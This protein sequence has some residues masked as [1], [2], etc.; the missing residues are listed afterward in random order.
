MCGA[1]SAW[2]H[3]GAIRDAHPPTCCQVPLAIATRNTPRGVN[4][5]L[6]AAGLPPDTFD[7]VLT[8]ESPFPEKPD[9]AIVLAACAAWGVPPDT[10]LMVGDTMDDMR[11]GSGAG[12]GTCLIRPPSDDVL[13]EDGSLVD[14]VIHS[15]CELEAMINDA[16]EAS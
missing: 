5:M 9:P 11:C 3:A 1:P 16:L 7:P 10:C 2:R 8:R 4:A 12:C 6:R 15:L 13:S 14:F